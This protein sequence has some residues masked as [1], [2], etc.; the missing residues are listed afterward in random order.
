MSIRIEAFIWTDQSSKWNQAAVGF[1]TQ[2][3]TRKR[4]VRLSSYDVSELSWLSYPDR[5]SRYQKQER[6]SKLAEPS[7]I[8]FHWKT[9]KTILKDFSWNVYK[10][11]HKFHTRRKILFMTGY[12]KHSYHIFDILYIVRFTKVKQYNLI[13][14][15]E[16][17]FGR[18]SPPGQAP[19]PQSSEAMLKWLYLLKLIYS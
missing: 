8:S 10:Q 4:N 9:L 13:W 6:S 5:H 12:Q 11:R 17:F 16:K 2:N 7:F 18:L 15:I 3:L 14:C 1:C 19:L